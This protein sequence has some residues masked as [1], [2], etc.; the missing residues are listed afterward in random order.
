MFKFIAIGYIGVVLTAIAQVI[1]KYG[2]IRKANKSFISFFVNIYTILG[3]GIMFGITLINLYIF[4]F[5]DLKYILIFLPSS[6]ILVFLFS[7]LI[8]KEKT[9]RR[10]LLQY[11]I[12]LLGILV[13]NL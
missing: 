13:F 11:G 2:A 5:L 1:L 8:L 12:V 7:A 6:Y 4:Q 10:R 3:Y 9:D